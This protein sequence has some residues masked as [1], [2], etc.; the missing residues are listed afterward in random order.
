MLGVNLSPTNFGHNVR[1]NRGKLI[2]EDIDTENLQEN[3]VYV[4]MNEYDS[5]DIFNCTLTTCHII[6]ISDADITIEDT[7]FIGDLLIGMDANDSKRIGSELTLRNTYISLSFMLGESVHL[8][9]FN[10][11]GLKISGYINSTHLKSN[12]LNKNTLKERDSLE[13]ETYFSYNN[14][15]VTKTAIRGEIHKFIASN[16]NVYTDST[17]ID[18]S[19]STKTQI[20][21]SEFRSMVSGKI[22]LD[23]SVLKDVNWYDCHLTNSSFKQIKAK[24][25]GFIR[26]N[27]E[28]TDFKDSMIYKSTFENSMLAFCSF[29]R[30][31]IDRETTFLYNTSYYISCESNNTLIYNPNHPD[32]SEMKE[33]D[34]QFEDEEHMVNLADKT[35]QV[36]ID[37]AEENN[38]KSFKKRLE[39]SRN[40]LRIIRDEKYST[41]LNRVI[42]LYGNST[43][44]ISFLCL[45]IVLLFSATYS[46]ISIFKLPDT[47][48]SLRLPFIGDLSHI[49]YPI[50]HS[51]LTFANI[52]SPLIVKTNRIGFVV[53][54]VQS[55]AGILIL[56][57]VVYFIADKLDL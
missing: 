8:T 20:S 3:K 28:R 5:V 16:L 14:K 18:L 36:L 29:E 21:N 1:E 34:R 53:E 11:D 57:L 38:L 46:L 47:H 51:T 45:C 39:V 50:I 10:I 54:G 4:N 6:N 37:L 27:L 48:I 52:D 12:T 49:F 56:G 22:I 41:K 43:Y 31:I 15:Q 35:Y 30:V 23:S 2:I 40:D 7:D 13:T 24:D 9:E 17:F 33:F 25:S 55:L 19:G 32:N 44:R 42:S 26:C